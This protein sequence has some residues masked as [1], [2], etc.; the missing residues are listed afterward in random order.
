MRP[1]TLT[2]VTLEQSGCAHVSHGAA[3]F[4]VALNLPILASDRLNVNDVDWAVEVM[5]LSPCAITTG[6]SGARRTPS[7][8]ATWTRP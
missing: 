7:G 5:Q 4:G 6:M 3:N 8:G 1:R 2:D